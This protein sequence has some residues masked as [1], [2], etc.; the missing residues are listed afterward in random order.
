MMRTKILIPLLLFGLVA[1]AMPVA[2]HARVSVGMT[3]R[4]GPPTLPVYVQPVCP[5]PVYLWTPGYWVYGDDGYYWVPGT[6]VEPP[7]VGVL[8]T[9]GYWG[10]RNGFYVWNG[11]YWGPHVGFYGGINYGFGY[12][13]TGYAGGYWANGAFNYNR[14]VNNISNTNI[15]NVYNQTV[16]NNTTVNNVSFNGGTGGTTAQPTPQEQATAREHH[17]PATGS[18]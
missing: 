7:M 2:S 13:G 15:T 14:T 9:P 4:V 12:V 18:Q 17:T 10:W 1:L 8:W 16:V 6:W 11:G 3:V 5:E